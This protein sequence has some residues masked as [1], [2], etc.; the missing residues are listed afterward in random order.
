MLNYVQILK[1]N[2]IFLIYDHGSQF[3]QRHLLRTFVC[4]YTS[5]ESKSDEDCPQI[6]CIR[7][8]NKSNGEDERTHDDHVSA[9][10]FVTEETTQRTYK[11][12]NVITDHIFRIFL[13]VVCNLWSL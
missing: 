7:R 12:N 8:H 9:G 10:E 6:W 4:T 5:Y 1:K 11:K 3:K 2:P 13:A